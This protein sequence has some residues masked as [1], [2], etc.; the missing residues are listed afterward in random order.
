MTQAIEQNPPAT[1]SES[2]LVVAVQAVLEASAEPLTPSKIRS[3]LPA[4]FRGGNLEDVLQRQVAARVLHQYPKY[5]SNQERFWDRP[6]PVHLVALVRAAL[7]EGPLGGSELRRKL[8]A[9]AQA[10]LEA[11]L[12]EQLQQGQ[13]HR[14]PRQGRTGERYG[15]R[16][17]D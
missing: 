4:R 3:A 11:L 8:P 12:E 10:D 14:H 2:D 1:A 15:L 7:S 17:A 16:Q 5:R 6:M 9:Y 13:I